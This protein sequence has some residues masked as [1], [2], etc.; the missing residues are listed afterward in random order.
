MEVILCHS[1]QKNGLILSSSEISAVDVLQP[2]GSLS[3]DVPAFYATL[4]RPHCKEDIPFPRQSLRWSKCSL[5]HGN[6][7]FCM[8]DNGFAKYKQIQSGTEFVFFATPSK[9]ANV[10]DAAAFSKEKYN[11]ELPP[12]PLWTIQAAVLIPGTTL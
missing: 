9:G 2:D 11:E 6:T 12:G 3:T 7:R 8:A 4:D 1:K 5:Q 10:R